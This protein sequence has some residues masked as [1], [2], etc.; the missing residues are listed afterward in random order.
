MGWIGNKIQCQASNASQ[1]L[2]P[3]SGN[4]VTITVAV[5]YAYVCAEPD[6]PRV[7]RFGT[8]CFQPLT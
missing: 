7:T 3:V 6:Q 1:G 4:M 8:R 5:N 2:A